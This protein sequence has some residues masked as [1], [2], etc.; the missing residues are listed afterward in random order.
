[1]RHTLLFGKPLRAL[2]TK[3]ANESCNWPRSEL[4]YGN[5]GRDWAIRM[6]TT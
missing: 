4:G 1:M 6:L 5:N 2:P 3:V